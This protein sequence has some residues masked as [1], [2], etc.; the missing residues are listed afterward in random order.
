VLPVRRLQRPCAAAAAWLLVG[1]AAGAAA[2]EPTPAAFGGEVEVRRIVTEVRVVGPDGEPV[3]G[4]GAEDF[5]VEVAGIGAEVESISWVPASAGAAEAAAGALAGGTSAPTEPEGRLI[6]V[7]FQIDP[8]F[9]SSRTSGLL[10]MTPKAAEFVAGLGPADRVAVLVFRSHLQLRADFTDDHRAVAE[11]LTPTRILEG[12]R[13]PPG[14]D[15][16]SLAAHLDVGEARDAASMAAAL[17]L[18]GTALQPIPGPK[19]LVLFGYALGRMT[20]GA[21]ITIDDGYRRAMEALTTARTSVF[22]LDITDA[23]YHSLERGLRTVSDDTG[24]IYVKTHEFPRLAMAKLGRVISSY[25]E[26]SII[27]PPGL[28]DEY[29]IEIRVRRPQTEVHV[30]QHHAASWMF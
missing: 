25:Y 17:E 10:R 28:G 5:E 22:A 3:L 18:I 23:D 20:A 16:P 2:Q 14:P 24:G 27:P 30:R 9:H 15:G 11:M 1:A 7:L 26:L 12:R 19:S 21:W 6:V 4:L 13:V 29:T 8:A